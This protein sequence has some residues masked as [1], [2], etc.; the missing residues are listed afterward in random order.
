MSTQRSG[1][2]QDA[3]AS[4]RS[5]LQGSGAGVPDDDMLATL[6]EVEGWDVTRAAR[7]V[8]ED[9]TAE[10]RRSGADDE[11]IARSFAQDP[12]VRGSMDFE[13]PLIDASRR[14]FNG[15]AGNMG[16]LSGGAGLR[17]YPG[18]GD[19]S[20]PSGVAQMIWTALTLPFSVASSLLLFLARVLR[21]RSLFPSLF[22]SGGGSQ[23][24]SAS[25][26]RTSAERFVRELELETGGT[27]SRSGPSTGQGPQEDG[28]DTGSSV[29]KRL[30]PFFVG[31]Y[32]DALRQAKEQIKILAIV[33]VSREHGDVDRFKQNTLT[34]NELVELLSRDDF[35]V[36][37]GDV[38]EREA[39]SVARTLQASTYPFVAFIALQPPRQSRRAAAASLGSSPRPAVLSR[40]EGS[41]SSATSA[42][43][44]ASHISDVLLPRTRVYM[45]RLRAE[46]RRH[47]MERELRAEQDRAY[48]EASRRDAERIAQ[49]REE[50]RRKAVEAQRRR[51][52][53]E[54]K[55]ELQRRQQ[56]WR[57]WAFNSLVPREPG[58]TQEA[59]RFS[60]RLPSGKTLARRFSPLDPVEAVFAYVESASVASEASEGRA[61]VRK[62]EGYEHTYRFSLVTGY[63]RKRI[64]FGDARASKLRDVEGLAQGASL[65]VE[66]HVLGDAASATDDEE[67]DD[68]D[69]DDDATPGGVAARA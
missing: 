27:T 68:D 62:P 66:G 64:E 69:D 54:Q 15:A 59:V 9:N 4:L 32:T 11:T 47:E 12:Q 18:P 49:R 19:N 55:E 44:I 43:S 60:V 3:I 30:P 48:Q 10:R 34:D 16:S 36:W 33:L 23:G 24:S 29:L 28:Y 6:L 5:I 17:R 65:I 51:E 58:A 39:Y 2:Q 45:D 63:P 22:G 31:S 40:L 25:D 56:V 14:S 52:E 42:A 57:R 21:L 38:R 41:P 35:I 50:E 1:S 26:P 46:R 37:G 7:L 13:Q 67:D 53:H 61:E 20:G 8:E